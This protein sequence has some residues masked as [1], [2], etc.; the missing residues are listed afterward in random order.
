MKRMALLGICLMLIVNS[1]IFSLA[2]LSVLSIA[3]LNYILRR[4]A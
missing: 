2:V 4:V 1:E 3:G